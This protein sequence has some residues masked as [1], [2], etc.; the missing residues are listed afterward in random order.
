MQA[1]LM[2]GVDPRVREELDL[3]WQEF[4]EWVQSHVQASTDETDEAKK[5]SPSFSCTW[6]TGGKRSKENAGKI[7]AL[8][9]D[10]DE[11]FDS[12]DLRKRFEPYDYLAWTTW[13]STPEQPA[14]RVVLRLARPIDH[15][16]LSHY[17]D[18]AVRLVGD[19]GRVDARTMRDPA[20]LWFLP[21]HKRSQSRNFRLWVHSGKQLN[22]VRLNFEGVPNINGKVREGYRNETV[23]RYLNQEAAKAVD[24]RDLWELAV[25][26]NRKH[27]DPPLTKKE[28]RVLVRSSKKWVTE[29]PSGV[30]RRGEYMRGLAAN[31][32][33]GDVG[34]DLG[35]VL[36][37]DA[38]IP[39]PLVG[40][41]VYPG[42]LLVS[43]RAK[44]GKSIL[45]MQLALA[46]ASGKPFLRS[47]FF[48]GFGVHG[49][50]AGVLFFA[51]EDKH[52][53]LKMRFSK[54]VGDG[55]LPAPKH[56]FR[57]LVADD[58]ET[59]RSGTDADGM[60]I[61]ER[62]VD[63]AYKRG[64]RL[65]VV[66]PVK[67]MQSYLGI[68]FGG[69]NFHDVDFEMTRYYT[70]VAQRYEGLAIVIVMHHGKRKAVDGDSGLVDPM[71]AIAS[72]S[73]TMAGIVGHFSLLPMPSHLREDEG[74]ARRRVLF[75]Y[76]RHTCEHKLWIEQ[77]GL[78]WECRGDLLDTEVTERQTEYFEALLSVHA[79]EKPVNAEKVAR[80]IGV[81]VQGA[82]QVL[83]RMVKR[84]AVYMGWKVVSARGTGYKLV[85]RRKKPASG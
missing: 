28:L 11:V 84:E 58:L 27:C 15:E 38:S 34:V 13:S 45:L 30:A 57:V 43:A 64:V 40:G 83:G 61:F 60:A 82:R 9:F 36:N 59:L 69:R 33:L 12:A 3:N 41:I 81:S 62:L 66:D 47:E 29:N 70:R 80:C 31:L 19:A 76:G 48:P 44:E 68:D 51:L 25:E 54:H 65:V 79:E 71:D 32:E 10:I 24:L 2:R 63:D 74:E 37:G 73:G 72:T 5:H 26:Y 35:T 14:W 23:M 78:L 20:R 17:V 1:S 67:A 46:F 4:C 18:W 50:G 53:E 21:R 42:A 22:L 6:F 56:S 55:A 16:Q 77:S 75:M 7:W 39:E 85:P 49:G 8:V 52:G